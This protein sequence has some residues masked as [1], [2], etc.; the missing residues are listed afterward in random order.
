M[1]PKKTKVMKKTKNKN[2]DAQKKQSCHEV[3]DVSPKARRESI[4]ALLVLLLLAHQKAHHH[5]THHNRF[6]ALFQDHP[7][8]T[9]PEENF[10]TLRC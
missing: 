7:G 4:A 3:S 10:W 1:E 9:V 6:M 2:R 5:H 8:E